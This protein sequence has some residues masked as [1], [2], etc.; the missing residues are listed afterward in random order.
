MT[1]T[2]RG[3]EACR[4]FQL[5][6]REDET[7]ISGT[8]VVA[9]GVLFPDGKAVLRWDTKVNST[10]FYD[11]VADLDAIHG[12]GGKTVVH[13]LDPA[14]PLPDYASAW[15][16]LRGYVQEAVVDGEPLNAGA[17]LD[18][19]DELKRRA[20]APGRDWLK[21]LTRGES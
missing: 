7:G 14:M 17:L 12:H 18:Y 10:V 20:L 19:V 1:E 4:R 2:S 8:G 13:W 11:S 5:I 15:T 16:E 21:N 9:Y 3:A 6:R